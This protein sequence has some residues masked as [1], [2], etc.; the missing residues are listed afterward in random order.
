MIT[1][2]FEPLPSAKDN[3][4]PP[5][6]SLLMFT[7]RPPF[8]AGKPSS[9]PTSRNLQSQ[10]SCAHPLVNS[11]VELMP[12]R[13]VPFPLAP[14]SLPISNGTRLLSY[15]PSPN[16]AWPSPDKI[17]IASSWIVNLLRHSS[18]SLAISR[19]S[20]RYWSNGTPDLRSSSAPARKEAAPVAS[21]V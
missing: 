21:S 15:P 18:S 17:S 3:D 5:I 11:L 19:Q 16:Y 20:A 2:S 10:R 13:T 1:R 12:Y 8:V 14:H 6:H 7:P 9:P 4:P